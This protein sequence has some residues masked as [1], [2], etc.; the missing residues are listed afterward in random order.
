MTRRTTWAVIGIFGVAGGLWLVGGALWRLG[1]PYWSFRLENTPLGD[2]GRERIYSEIGC[3]GGSAGFRFL[4][5]E[6][7]TLLAH[8][9]N[10]I[11]LAGIVDGIAC[12]GDARATDALLQLFRRYE[13]EPAGRY[14]A[15]HAA[16]GLQE[17]SGHSFS[18]AVP[19][20]SAYEKFGVSNFAGTAEK[21]READ[22]R[23]R[24]L[25]RE[26]D[27]RFG[28]GASPVPQGR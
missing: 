3:H 27:E 10:D 7:E 18:E 26:I 14:V 21:Q 28:G 4:V 20:A 11:E 24:R 6:L 23:F 17:I 1:E 12:S 9:G 5:G 16:R 8:G 2:E 25:C 19:S 22:E 15:I 13:S